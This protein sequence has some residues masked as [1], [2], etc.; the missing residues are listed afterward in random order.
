M[1]AAHGPVERR[2]RY[3]PAIVQYLDVFVGYWN[4]GAPETL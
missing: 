3:L 2:N 4:M 1:P